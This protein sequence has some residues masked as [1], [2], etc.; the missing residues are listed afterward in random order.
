MSEAPRVAVIVLSWNGREDTLACLGSVS[1]STYRPLDL[2]CVDNGSSD[3]SADAVAAAFPEARLVRLPQN[4]GFAGGMNAGLHAALEA[5][6]DAVLTLNNDMVV[7]SRFVEPLVDALAAD[8]LAAAA[9]SQVLFADPPDRVWYAG[10]RWR[11]RRGHHGR[12]S[13]YGGPPL[14]DATPAF[15]TERACAG[16]M[17][18][19]RAAL[20]RVGVFDESLFAYAEDVDWSLRAREVGLHVLVVPASVVRHRVSAASGGESSPGTIYYGLRNGLVVAERHVPL[21]RVGTALRRAE[22][23]AA[24]TAQVLRAGRRR[25]GLLAVLQGWRDARRRRLGPRGGTA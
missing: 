6:A 10:A 3:G 14:D 12:H 9:C 8:P 21:G 20:E 4:L 18:S 25:E 13:G 24:S 15:V 7:D 1:R 17:L 22:A 19:P 5:G 11:P 16:A 2:V 23:V